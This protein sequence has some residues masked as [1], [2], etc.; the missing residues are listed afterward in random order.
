MKRKYFGRGFLQKYIINELA[1]REGMPKWYA[2]RKKQV[3][4]FNS[5]PH[6]IKILKQWPLKNVSEFLKMKPETLKNVLLNSFDVHLFRAQYAFLNMEILI[7]LFIHNESH[8]TIENEFR[9]IV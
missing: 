4:P 8:E 2:Y 3:T 5:I 1:I 6:I 7:R 9:N